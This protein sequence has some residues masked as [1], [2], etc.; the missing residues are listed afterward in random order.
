VVVVLV[1]AADKASPA[2]FW[3]HYNMVIAHYNIVIVIYLLSD[4]QSRG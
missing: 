3:V 2:G 1:N 4:S